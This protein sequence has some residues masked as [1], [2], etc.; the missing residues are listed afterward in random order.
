MSWRRKWQPTPVFF[1]GE[2]HGQRSL[3][4]YSPWGCKE[5]DTSEWLHLLTFHVLAIINSSAVNIGVHVSCQSIVFSQYMPRSEIAGSYGS[6][7]FSFLRNF[8]TISIVAVPIYIPIHS[9]G[10]F[11]FPTPSPAFIVCGL[12][13]DGH[14][15]QCEVILCCSFS[16]LF[17][18]INS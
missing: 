2:S 6:L 13:N 8:H 5:S 17:S 4:G 12:F 14:S 18:N 15:D 7:I 3:V 10:G 1:P 9:V 16:Y 11:L